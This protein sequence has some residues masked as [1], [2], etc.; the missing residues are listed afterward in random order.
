MNAVGST[1]GFGGVKEQHWRHRDPRSK[2]VVSAARMVT[3]DHLPAISFD[4]L[5]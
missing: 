1:K 2:V 4:A 5:P 3:D